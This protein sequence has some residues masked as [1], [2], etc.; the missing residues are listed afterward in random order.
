MI[1]GI[2]WGGEPTTEES[3]EEASFFSDVRVNNYPYR[4]RLLRWFNSWGHPL[5]EN[6]GMEGAFERSII[7]TNWMPN[8]ARTMKGRNIWN[9][10][11]S[12]R[13]N[14]IKHIDVLKPRLLILCSSTLLRIMNNDQCLGAV[15]EILGNASQIQFERRDI[16]L[17]GRKL[18]RFAVGFQEFTNCC[19]IALP[20]P[21]GSVGLSDQYIAAFKE[22]IGGIINTFREKLPPN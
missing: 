7:Q 6:A 14:F 11:I 1:C 19:V 21:T 12:E 4:N 9:E 3:P 13:Q 22:R 17:N 15:E 8:Q 5:E 18:K 20:H 16:S 10:C 2:N